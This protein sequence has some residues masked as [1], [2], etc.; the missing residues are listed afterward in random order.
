[1]SYNK[2]KTDPVLG[3]EI[4]KHLVEAGVETPVEDMQMDRKDKIASI[5]QAKNKSTYCH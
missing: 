3:L 1:M 4:H 2:T 5:E